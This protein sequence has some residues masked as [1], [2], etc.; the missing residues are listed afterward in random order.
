MLLK[1][2]SPVLSKDL[3][4]KQNQAKSKIIVAFLASLWYNTGVVQ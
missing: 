3:H 1:K 2:S 4:K